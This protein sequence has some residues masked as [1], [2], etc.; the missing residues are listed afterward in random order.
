MQNLMNLGFFSKS[1]KND[2]EM[3]NTKLLRK[4]ANWRRSEA[5]G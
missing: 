4:N 1:N 3:A 2:T 5:K